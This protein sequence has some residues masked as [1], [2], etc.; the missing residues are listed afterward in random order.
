MIYNSNNN[1]D[2]IDNSNNNNYDDNGI[3][4]EMNEKQHYFRFYK[5]VFINCK[6]NIL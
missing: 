5:Y 4:D 2:I 1:S 3:Y 6:L